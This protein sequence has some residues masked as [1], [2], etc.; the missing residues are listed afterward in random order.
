MTDTQT[1][2]VIGATGKTGRRVAERLEA[3]GRTVRRLARGTTPAF[4]WNEPDGWSAALAGLDRVYVAFVPD[5]AAFGSSEA[6]AR[7]AEVA[8]AAGVAR[9]VLLSGRGEDG[10]RAAEDVLL[11]SAVDAT[12]V[13]ASWFAQNFTEGMLADQ[14]AGGFVAIPAGERREPFIDVD[15]LADVAVEALTGDGHEGRV[16]EV[17]GPELLGFADVA[18]LLTELRGHPVAYLAVSLD[19]FHAAIEAE[20]G[21]EAADL[22]TELC[23]EVFDGRNESLASGVRDA[24]GR[25]PRSLREVLTAAPAQVD[26]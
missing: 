26:A 4:D 18:A 16:F 6:I 5:L 22:L 23:R 14:V 25:E 19:E 8:K 17:T 12:I 15:D 11:A 21:P 20:E 24:L 1:F 2:G 3:Q 13:R 10:A 7:L 9:I